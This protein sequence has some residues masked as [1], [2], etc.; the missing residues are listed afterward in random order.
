MSSLLYS[1]RKNLS[2]FGGDFQTAYSTFLHPARS[3]I[4]E[5]SSLKHRLRQF[6]NRLT[7][8]SKE[9]P[10]QITNPKQTSH[11]L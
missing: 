1:P 11:Y 3:S 2:D 9:T 4:T 10:G 8:A 5:Q 7:Q 6:T